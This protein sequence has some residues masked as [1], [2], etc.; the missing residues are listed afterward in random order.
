MVTRP[1][2]VPR[3][4]DCVGIPKHSVTTSVLILMHL[5]AIVYG[6]RQH[7]DSRG[8]QLRI[9]VQKGGGHSTG[10]IFMAQVDC[11]HQI[12]ERIQQS[13]HS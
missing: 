3:G 12:L 6:A 11:S 4:S 10:V 5:K 8:M 1:S 7:E 9:S 2:V 13:R